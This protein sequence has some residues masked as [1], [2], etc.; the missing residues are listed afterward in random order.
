MLVAMLGSSSAERAH[1]T[2][3]RAGL[4]TMIVRDEAAVP[5]PS[6]SVAFGPIAC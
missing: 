6:H 2:T 1:G 4:A 3:T 5:L